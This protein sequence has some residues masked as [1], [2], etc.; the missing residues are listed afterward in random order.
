MAD[1]DVHVLVFPTCQVLA[2]PTEDVL[3][4][5]WPATE[6]PTNTLLASQAILPGCSM[7][8][9]LTEEGEGVAG[10]FPERAEVVGVPYGEQRL[11][12]VAF[13]VEGLMTRIEPPRL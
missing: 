12:E 11:L 13:C 4:G 1:T 9:G 7:P 5:Q 6:L 10:G 3:A 2:P 8:V